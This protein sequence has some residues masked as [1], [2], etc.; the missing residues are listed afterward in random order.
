MKELTLPWPSRDLHPNARVHWARKAKAVKA[1]RYQ[2]GLA[3]I[4]A[5]FRV[6]PLPHGRIHLYLDFYPPNRRRHDDDGLL[7]SMKAARDGIAD[8]LGIDDNR[9]VSHPYVRDEVRKGG[10]VVVR[11]TG[12]EDGAG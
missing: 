9:F 10:Q 7:S 5:G 2:A 6:H 11:I 12:E 4:A 8:A 1:A 3:A